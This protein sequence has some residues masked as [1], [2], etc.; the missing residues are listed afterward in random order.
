M[1]YKINIEIIRKIAREAGKAILSIYN[2]AD[3]SKVVDFKTDNSPLT[4]ADQASHQVIDKGLKEAYPEIPV[5]SEEGSQVAYEERRNWPYFW[6]IDPLDGT[7]EFINRNGEFTVNI[8]LI[9]D[10]KPVLGVIYTPVTDDLYEGFVG[11]YARKIQNGELQNLQVN[12]KSDNRIAVRSK[13][14]PSPEEESV[15]KSH[16]VVD[17]ISVGSSLKFCMVAEG[18]ADIYY[19]HGPTMEWDTAAGQAVLEAAGGK[20]YKNTGSEVFTYNK[21]SLLNGSFLCLG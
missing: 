19:R 9:K 16:N 8:A 11:E 15:L 2:D 12:N 13:S 1:E 10:R 6:L 18:K 3:F 20:V 5:I 14:H 4:L 21:E 17:S 7:K